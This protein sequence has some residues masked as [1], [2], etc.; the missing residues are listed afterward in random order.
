MS[1]N[2]NTN[3]E[4]MDSRQRK[5]HS[6]ASEEYVQVK[7][8]YQNS[9]WEGWVPVKYRRTGT[10]IETDDELYKYLNNVYNQLDPKEYPKWLKDQETF[11]EEKSRAI[12]TKG[13]FDCLIKGGWQCVNCT[14]PKNP[15]W[16]RRIQDLK[17]F[18]YT[19]STDTNRYCERCKSNTSHILLIP[20]ARY[21]IEGFGYEIIS[22][23]LRKRILKVLNNFDVYENRIGGHLL[24]DHKFSEIR[25]DELT[26][27]KL[28]DEMSDEDIRD[29]F[30]LLSNQRN[31]QKREVCRNCY[32]TGERGTI[33]GIPYFH[34][35]T[36][37][38]DES[39]PKIGKEAEQ[40][41]RGCAWYDISEWRD[42]IIKQLGGDSM[43]KMTNDEICNKFRANQ[44]K[45]DNR[46]G[47]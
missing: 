12:V 4:I 31:Q 44:N 46:L 26:K 34:I 13:F 8:T 22:T 1:E 42:N 5:I 41:C 3:I 10:N 23:V 18:G 37:K 15:N 29:K 33:F 32:Q 2:L 21:G 47:D 24:P 35:G 7:F 40:G 28:S 17:D 19:L 45:L 6:K 14:L 25:W 9:V 30:Q 27:S 39:I 36:N 20:I 11:W 38:W 16:A 43:T